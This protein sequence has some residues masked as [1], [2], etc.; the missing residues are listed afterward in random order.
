MGDTQPVALAPLMIEQRGPLRQLKFIGSGLTDFHMVLVRDGVDA[1]AALGGL[2]DHINRQT[3]W[4]LINLEQVPNDSHTYEYLAAQPFMAREMTQCPVV[5][6][7]SASFDDYLS[8]LRRNHRQQWKKKHRQMAK[9]GRLSLRVIDT[10]QAKHAHLS[11]LFDLHVRRWDTADEE[12]KLTS[13]TVRE[14]VADAVES[15][16]EL[17]G[18]LLF[19]EDKLVSYRIGF[20]AD[21]V[22]YDWNTA[23]DPDYA[24]LA[25]GRV[26]L[27][28]VIEDLISR[29]FAHFHFMR[30]N[31]PYKRSWM[32]SDHTI[33]NYQFLRPSGSLKGV[34][35]AQYYIKW[36]AWLK[37]KLQF[38]L[39]DRRI[40]RLRL[41]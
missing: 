5:D 15:M 13:N 8:K 31:Y 38:L 4:D 3:H 32:T 2:F 7:G 6:L 27:G 34:I 11:S 21:G 36:K 16:D 40:Q 35:A 29:N 10:R 9:M 22:F 37:T 19:L 14:F 1:Q 41:R 39:E 20:V 24:R 26:L 30:G 25:V 23:F 12:S 18:Y 28:L 33:T 17:I